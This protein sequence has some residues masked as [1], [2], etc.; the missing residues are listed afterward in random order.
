MGQLALQKW[1]GLYN[2]GIEA[3][4]EIRR[5][6]DPKMNVGEDLTYADFPER[7]PYSFNEDNLNLDNYEAAAAAI[8]GDSDQTRLFWDVAASP[9]D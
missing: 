3:W 2:R 5:L 9:Y 7:M 4:A 8:G 6:D 1:L